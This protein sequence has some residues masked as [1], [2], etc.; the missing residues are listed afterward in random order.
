ME[1]IH[2]IMCRV[3]GK[4]LDVYVEFQSTGD[5]IRAVERH[6]KNSA[7]G[8]P[9]RIGDR[10]VEVSVA[11]K[12]DLMRELF[13]KANGVEWTDGQPYI[14]ETSDFP[15]RGFVSDEELTM[16]VKHVE[17]PHRVS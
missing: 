4:T 10:L 2:V 1:P 3:T 13:P 11:G 15:F 16:L 5:A 14:Y 8:R 17:N 6:L 12:K 7:A 9:S